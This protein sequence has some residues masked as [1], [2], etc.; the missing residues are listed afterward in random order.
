MT[1]TQAVILVAG[2][3][4]AVADG[5]WW[6]RAANRAIFF[7]PLTL[8]RRNGMAARGRIRAAKSRYS[9]QE[10]V[11]GAIALVVGLAVLVHL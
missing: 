3:G 11:F 9:K 6:H 10:A 1:T 2:G 5:L 8:R 7:T 4:F